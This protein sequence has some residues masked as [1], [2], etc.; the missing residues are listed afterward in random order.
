MKLYLQFISMH[1][2]SQMQ[3]KLSF[4]FTALG[5]FLVSFTLLVSI[6]FMLDRFN[7]IE[8]FT[9]PQVLLAFAVVQ[10]AFALAECIG[11]G[12]D[13]FPR[14]I[15]SGEF[16]RILVR[17]RPVVFQVLASQIDFIRVGRL[18]QAVLVLAYALPASGVVWAPDKIF[19]LFLMIAC[20]S[21]I[22]FCLFLVYASL[23][24]FTIEG[25]EFMNILTHGGQEFG[26]YPFSI[27]GKKVLAF[28][29]YVVPL[30]LFQYYPLLYLLGREE[31]VLYMLLPLAGLLF[32]FPSYAIW[33]FGLRRYQSTGS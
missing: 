12:F 8:G 20:G 28:L 32:A 24:F 14:L 33:R 22:F 21:I 5:Q 29:T 6:W 31:S 26:K 2:K 27:Y 4:F 1:F 23:A 25:L 30:A 11:R 17:P 3:Y 16:D 18:L 15:R 13:A 9:F 7:Q 19:T 10:M